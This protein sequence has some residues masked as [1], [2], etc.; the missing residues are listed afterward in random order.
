VGAASFPLAVLVVKPGDGYTFAA[1]TVLAVFIA[2]THRANIRRLLAGTENRFGHTRG[3]TP[4][5]G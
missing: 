4:E 1:G 5:A 3:A 2:Y